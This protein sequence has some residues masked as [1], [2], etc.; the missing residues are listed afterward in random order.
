[1]AL[2]FV[3]RFIKE[4]MGSMATRKKIE[5]KDLTSEHI[6]V[7]SCGNLVEYYGYTLCQLQYEGSGIWS[8]FNILFGLNISLFGLETVLFT[9][10]FRASEYLTLIIAIGGILFSLWSLYVM[11]RLWGY[12]DHWKEMVCH[13]EKM[14][15]EYY[16]KPFTGIPSDLKK[17]KTKLGKWL[18]SYTQPFFVILA[19][20]WFLLILMNHKIHTDIQEQKKPTVIQH[21]GTVKIKNDDLIEKSLSTGIKLDSV[22]TTSL[23]SDTISTINNIEK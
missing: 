6:D 23:G 2:S 5:Q 10:G 20:I 22:S 11:Q 17:K 18:K 8:R 19:V 7:L 14:L 4:L 9:I 15:P 3:V 12:H 13:A 1:M 21:E 16:I